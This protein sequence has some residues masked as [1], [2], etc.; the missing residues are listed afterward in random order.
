MDIKKLLHTDPDAPWVKAF[1]WALAAA[2]LGYGIYA[3]S[4]L[5][6]GLGLFGVFLAW[7]RPATRIQNVLKKKIVK[8]R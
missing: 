6:I 8:R 5:F 7:Y 1:D 3:Q 2:G 4:Y